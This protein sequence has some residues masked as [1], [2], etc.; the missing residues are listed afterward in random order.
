M[1]ILFIIPE[2]FG[3]ER[4]GGVTTYTVELTNELRR[5]GH[6]VSILTPG[7]TDELQVL[8]GICI[9]KISH[10]TQHSIIVRVLIKIV[11][12]L[13][14]DILERLLWARDVVRFV[15]NHGP[16]DVIEA[17]EWGSSTL[18]LSCN[19]SLKIVVRLHKS[20]FMYKLDNAWPI[21]LSDRAVDILE[22][23]CIIVSSAVTS[24]TKYMVLQ[25]PW[26]IRVLRLRRVAVEVIPCGIVPPS[27]SIPHKRHISQPYILTVGRVETGKGSVILAKAFLR[28]AKWQKTIQLVYIGEDTKMFIH[29]QRESCVSYIRSLTVAYHDRV[30]ILS[31]QTR[32]ALSGYFAHCLF[33]VAPS[34]GHENA[35]LSIIEALMHRKTVIGCDVG[36]IPELVFHKTNGL[37]CKEDNVEDLVDKIQLMIK[38]HS[39]RKSC[40]RRTVTKRYQIDIVGKTTLAFYRSI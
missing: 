9:Y 33:L 15:Y 36:G 3:G 39:L 12:R 11:R 16:F 13:S 28:I 14:P 40:E 10:G 38:N 20:W 25:Y 37:L 35:P 24:P 8:R 21:T 2:E 6:D 1:K 26:I 17:P 4:W 34:R 27:L 30:I 22:R 32:D 18:L 23:L 7:M 19:R 31:R 5:L 29:G